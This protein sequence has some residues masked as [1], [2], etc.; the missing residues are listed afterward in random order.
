MTFSSRSSIQLV[1]FA[2]E[3]VASGFSVISLKLDGSKSSAKKKAKKSTSVDQLDFVVLDQ[4]DINIG[5]DSR[6]P[7]SLNADLLSR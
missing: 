7:D 2:F 5:V 4:P 3:Y 6:Y 1:S